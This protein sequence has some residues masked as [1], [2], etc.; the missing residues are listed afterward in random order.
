M[1]TRQEDLAE[2]VEAFVSRF[3]RLQDHIGDKLSN[4]QLF[5]QALLAAREAAEMLFGGVDA[6]EAQ[7][8]SVGLIED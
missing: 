1:L 8:K 7:A 3:G 4:P 5:L 2:N 6:V